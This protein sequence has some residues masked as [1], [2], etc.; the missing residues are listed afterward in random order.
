MDIL[1]ATLS[2]WIVAQ[3][4]L[5]SVEP[6]RIQFVS[7]PAMT[8]IAFGPNMGSN[9]QLRALYSQITATVYLRSGWNAESLRD[10]S[11]LVHE[12]VHHFQHMHHLKYGCPA[13]GETLAYQLQLAWLRE[14]GVD[15]PYGLI[16]VNR[17]YILLSAICRD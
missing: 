9:P 7:P 10:R 12:L 11:E 1:I 13:A 5:S 3:T 16:E 17:F 15:D 2:A 8:E 4:G 6:P 14:N